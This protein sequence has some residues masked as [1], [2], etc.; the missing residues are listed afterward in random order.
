MQDAGDPTNAIEQAKSYYEYVE[1]KAHRDDQ[2][3]GSCALAQGCQ[4]SMYDSRGE[5]RQYDKG[6][7][8]ALQR[9]L[10]GTAALKDLHT[11]QLLLGYCMA[12]SL[13]P[14]A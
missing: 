5:A 12:T 9:A 4:G 8:E 3:S 2:V 1:E 7:T 6:K 11:A 14:H 13:L 10:A